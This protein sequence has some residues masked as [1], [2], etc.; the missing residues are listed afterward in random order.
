VLG[1]QAQVEKHTAAAAVPMT[2]ESQIIATDGERYQQQ[3][4]PH[5]CGG[6]AHDSW[7]NRRRDLTR[8]RRIFVFKGEHFFG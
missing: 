6:D 4:Q 7:H 8:I 1:G 3:K 2:I 5:N